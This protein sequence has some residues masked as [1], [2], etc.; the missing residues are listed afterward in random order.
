ME[1]PKNAT[2]YNPN[3]V[4]EIKTAD[5]YKYPTVAQTNINTNTKIIKVG[6]IVMLA[7]G[8]ISIESG[9]KHNFKIIHNT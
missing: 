7:S 2:A 9:L 6:N 5:I 4:I 3:I 8:E 1:I